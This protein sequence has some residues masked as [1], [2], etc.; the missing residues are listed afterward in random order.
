MTHPANTSRFL[1]GLAASVTML[2]SSV[3]AFL[4]LGEFYNIKIR[5]QYSGY[6]FGSEGPVPYYY[7][8]PALYANV[9]LAWGLIF[10]L[11][12]LCSVRATGKRQRQKILLL[13]GMTILL[14]LVLLIQGQVAD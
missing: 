6:P 2:L 4:N 14:L 8:T 3:M 12:F 5:R 1:F 10:L 9:Q 13:L 7:K 11:V